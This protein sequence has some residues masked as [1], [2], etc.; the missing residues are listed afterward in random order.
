MAEVPNAVKIAENYNRVGCTSVTDD[1]QTT[2][3]RAT[4]ISERERE[5][6]FTKNDLASGFPRNL[7]GMGYCLKVLTHIFMK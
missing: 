3:G 4:A 7:D 1:R 5:F 2:D 6:T